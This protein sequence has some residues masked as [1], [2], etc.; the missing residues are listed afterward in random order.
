MSKKQQMEVRPVYV[1]KLITLTIENLGSGAH[2]VGHFEG[3]AIFVPGALPEEVVRARITR[4]E[5]R[6]ATAQLEEVITSSPLRKTPFCPHYTVCG[7]CQTQH[8][9]YEASLA[10]KQQQVV[11]CLTHIAGIVNPPVAP[12]VGMETPF[13]YR[14]KAQY[15]VGGIM[16]APLLGF[17]Q[18]RSHAIVDVTSCA[19]QHPASLEILSCV[20]DWMQDTEIAPYNEAQHRGSLRHVVTRVNRLGHAMAILVTHGD[21]LPNSRELVELLRTRVPNLKS[22]LHNINP[23]RTAQVLGDT[24]RT[25][26]GARSLEDTMGDLTFTLNAPSFFQVNPTQAEVLLDLATKAAALTGDETVLDIY[27]GAGTFTLPLSRL[28]KRIIGVDI[29]PEAIAD[30]KMNAQ[31]NNLS[32]EFLAG[33]AQELIPRLIADGIRPHV[34][35]L[36]PPRKGADP[37]VLKAIGQA[38]PAR[39]VY[40][41]C[42]PATL[43]RDV[44]TLGEYG[45]TLTC[46]TPVDMFCHT[47]HVECVVLMTRAK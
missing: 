31:Q 43:A 26:W 3:F 35:L 18:P 29:V 45:Y 15:P 8:M 46:A 37:A 33:D 34:V 17:F 28:A 20:R 5:A 2:A 36:D 23:H 24:Y 13:E 19:L 16:Y 9:T 22:I 42:N 1:K 25:L 4:V 44:K 47:S 41:S 12:C 11:D 7:G 32:A 27:C 21:T 10:Y 30:G 6:Y 40:V 39:I 38:A 14:N